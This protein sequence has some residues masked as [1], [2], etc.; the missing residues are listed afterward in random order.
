MYRSTL[1]RINAQTEEEASLAKRAI[2]WLTYAYRSLTI[3]ELQH[4]LAVTDGAGMFDEEDI[5]SEKRII[6]VCCGLITIGE[7]STIV[8]LVRECTIR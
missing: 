7:E 1:S 6:A 2:T 8:R 3:S 4:G 5:A